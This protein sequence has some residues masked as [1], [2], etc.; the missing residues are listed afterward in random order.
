MLTTDSSCCV[1]I[2]KRVFDMV[3]RDVHDGRSEKKYVRKTSNL[4]VTLR[5]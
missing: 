2:T 1:D 5:A 3:T 4:R